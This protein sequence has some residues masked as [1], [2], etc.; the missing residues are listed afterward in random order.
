MNHSFNITSFGKNNIKGFFELLVANIFWGFGFV[1]TVWCLNELS[2][3]AILFYRF[4]LA[5][6]LSQITLLIIYKN[7]IFPPLLSEIKNISKSN[8]ISLTLKTQNLFYYLNFNFL[9][10]MKYEIGLAFF[11]G[12]FLF[13][14]LFLQTWGLKYTTATKSGF[15]T[16]LYVLLVTLI[17]IIHIKK[18]PNLKQWILTFT[19]FSG[20]LFMIHVLNLK[21]LFKLLFFL[22]NN[23]DLILIFINPNDFAEIINHTELQFHDFISLNQLQNLNW[24]DLLTF[25]CAITAAFHIYSIGLYSNKTRSGWFLNGYQSLWCAI[26]SLPFMWIENDFLIQ[27]PPSPQMIFGLLAL[28][29]GSSYLA[30]YLQVKAQTEISSSLASMLFLM[31]SPFAALFGFLL[32]SEKMSIEQIFGALLIFI[33]CILMTIQPNRNKTLLSKKKDSKI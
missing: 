32:L 1:A 10:K 16:I 5:F 31:E 11:P 30:F 24:G 2:P 33:S 20:A 7:R 27:F 18:H 26:F 9:K 13:L 19:A 12:L 15:I 3:S 28:G 6:I 14:T 8:S 4:S 17:E 25:L 21:Y 23:K 22:T 29:A